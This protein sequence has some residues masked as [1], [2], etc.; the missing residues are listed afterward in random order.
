M[1][2]RSDDSALGRLQFLE[3]EEGAGFAAND[4]ELLDRAETS[5]EN[6]AQVGG[7]NSLDDSLLRLR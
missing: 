5:G 3:F 6:R 7:V 4:F 2:K 1:R